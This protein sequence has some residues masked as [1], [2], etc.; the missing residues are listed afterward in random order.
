MSNESRDT[1]SK[2]LNIHGAKIVAHQVAPSRNHMLFFTS[3]YQVASKLVRLVKRESWDRLFNMV[4][5]FGHTILHHVCK[6]NNIEMAILLLKL[7]D[8]KDQL[9]LSC[10]SDGTALHHVH[11]Y[12]L[13]QLLLAH[14][15]KEKQAQLLL[16][17]DKDGNTAL[18][19]ATR[20]QRFDVMKCLLNISEPSQPTGSFADWGARPKHTSAAIAKPLG[21]RL[22]EVADSCG[23]TVLHIA[24]QRGMND[25]VKYLMSLGLVDEDMLFKC[26]YENMKFEYGPVG[27]A[28]HVA[29]HAEMAELLITAVAESERW[30][31]L[32]TFNIQGKTA[33]HTACKEEKKDVVQY[34]MSLDQF[35]S[36]L[37][38]LCNENGTA[39]H[40]AKS[41]DM[42]A[43]ILQ[44]IPPTQRKSLLLIGDEDG[45]TFL[46]SACKA[47]KTS[48]VEYLLPV[49]ADGEHDEAVTFGH[50]ANVEELWSH[51]DLV[52][53]INRMGE[54]LLHAATKSGDC[55]LVSYLL[56]LSIDTEE[57]LFTMC[58]Q[59]EG[60]TAICTSGTALHKAA[61]VETAKV[62]VDAVSKSRRKEFVTTLNDWGET[63]LHEASDQSTGVPLMK[64]LLSQVSDKE[65]YVMISGN[66]QGTALH[67]SCKKEHAKLLFDSIHIDK[68]EAFI[69]TLDKEERSALHI[70]CRQGKTDVA[71]FLLSFGKKM[72]TRAAVIPKTILPKSYPPTNISEGLI[73]MPDNN[74]NTPFMHAINSGFVRLVKGMLQFFEITA[75]D[76]QLQL[77]HQNSLQ[78]NAF[79]LAARHT[80]CDR[81]M[82]HIRDCLNE[83]QVGKILVKDIFGNSPLHYAAAMGN[84]ALFAT[85][86]MKI[87]LE[88]RRFMLM[89][90]NVNRLNPLAIVHRHSDYSEQAD[91]MFVIRSIMNDNVSTCLSYYYS[92][93]MSLH[94]SFKHG[95][96]V[97][98]PRNPKILNVTMHSILIYSLLDQAS[99]A[100]HQASTSRGHIK[101]EKVCVCY[102]ISI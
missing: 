83:V 74:G 78:Q 16:S 13:A 51:T 10:G 85:L 71:A 79:H 35:G 2:L 5:E 75:T 22:F 100:L 42:V 60:T 88:K 77:E 90:M 72:P 54:T 76:V 23:R 97:S 37:V 95:E 25:F 94:H 86:L 92:R 91:T 63:A 31:F 84:V 27:T 64:F 73:T 6:K 38:F 28:L 44:A 48:I 98:F 12:R 46:H 29:S 40:D 70:A 11:D 17:C 15:S 20:A 99:T 65:S 18:H 102:T 53:A 26:S 50:N 49:K 57:L 7:V 59:E 67:R 4:N 41:R 43:L 81:Y 93:F 80:E 8:D 1:K 89:Q 9:I 61:N 82:S 24:S 62:L 87:P 34:L 21:Q 33:L 101:H 14:L 58:H 69:L 47:G 39:L 36:Q 56:S 68:H 96:E 55:K 52:F 32:S 45:N 30:K 66:T 3:N 19:C